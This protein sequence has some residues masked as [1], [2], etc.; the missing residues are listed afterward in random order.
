MWEGCQQLVSSAVNDGYNE[1]E[2]QWKIREQ[3]LFE[4]RP[5]NFICEL[6]DSLLQR[7]TQVKCMATAHFLFARDTSKHQRPPNHHTSSA[8]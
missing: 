1:R 6:R 4:R 5:V 7:K 3:V 2:V 8:P